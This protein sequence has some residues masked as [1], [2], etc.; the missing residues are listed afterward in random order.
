MIKDITIGQFFPGNSFIHKLDARAKIVLT[1][2][3]IIALF[4]CKNFFSLLLM[5]GFSAVCVFISKISPKLIWKSLRAIIFIVLFTSA[6]Q[7][8]YNDNG[9]IL[10]KPFE[11]RDFA[12]TTGGVFSAVFLAV[13]II[14]LILL[15]SLLTY[16]T[17]PTMLTDAIERLLS[18][19]KIFKVKVHALAMMMTIALRFIPTLITEIDII[20]SAQ[21][22]RGA[23]LDSGSIPERMKAMISVFI[24]LFVS[25]FRRAAELAVAMECRCYTD[26]AS[27]TSLKV[28]RMGIRDYISFAVLGAVIFGAV[29]TSFYKFSSMFIFEP[30]M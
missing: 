19:L 18:P 6:L 29:F 27:R 13:R 30:V 21:K 14:A 24:P 5:L 25:A 22:A 2:L 15:S 10:W 4:M 23:K 9:E 3:Y 7:I 8:I 26:S 12:V 28:M 1:L 17:S 11:S 16:T 20:M